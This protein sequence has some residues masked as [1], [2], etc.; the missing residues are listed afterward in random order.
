MVAHTPDFKINC[1]RGGGHTF[2][3][4]HILNFDTQKFMLTPEFATVM[5]SQASQIFWL[6]S[7]LL[8]NIPV[9]CSICFTWRFA[10]GWLRKIISANE[11]KRHGGRKRIENPKGKDF[12]RSHKIRSIYTS[13]ISPFSPPW[14]ISLHST[15]MPLI[16]PGDIRFRMK[17]ISS[18]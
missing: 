18:W 4:S 13:L 1:T 2:S 7:S 17:M 12:L 11:T 16:S 8:K 3:R 9:V 6:H 10:C 14:I 15:L 5:L